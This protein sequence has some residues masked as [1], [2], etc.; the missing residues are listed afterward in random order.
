MLF[1]TKGV[2]YLGHVI[3]EEGIFPMEDKIEAIQNVRR[4][5]TVMDIKQC[6]SVIGFMEN[7][8]CFF[9]CHDL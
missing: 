8:F 1:F 3:P 6:L 5:A 7:V 4:L 9:I 2:H